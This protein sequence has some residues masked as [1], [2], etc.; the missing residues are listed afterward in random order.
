MNGGCESAQ[1][2]DQRGCGSVQELVA[3]AVDAA[4]ADGP[5]FSPPAVA[6]DLLQWNPVAGATPGGDPHFGIFGQHSL[7]IALCARL[8]DEFA[9]CGAHQFRH[10]WLRRDQWL[11]PFFAE[12]TG[13]GCAIG[14]RTDCLDLRLHIGDHLRATFGRTDDPG[15]RRNVGVN[16]SQRF[17]G[18]A[19]KA[20]AGLENLDNRLLLVR[21]CGDH[22][23]GMYGDD[24]I[25]LRSPGIGENGPPPIR[26]L[27][28]D[29]STIPGAG[30]NAVQFAENSKNDGRAGLQANDTLR[31]VVGGHRLA[32][33][34][35]HAGGALLPHQ[36]RTLQSGCMYSP[37]VLDHFEHPRNAGEVANPDASA[38]IENPACG[39][40]LKLTMKVVGGRI[41][42][43]RF[44]AKGCV[45]AMACGSLLTQLV[46]GRPV[47]EARRLRREEL[48]HS[49]GGL[50]E[51]SGH[52]SHLA[53]DALAAALKQL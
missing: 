18:E 7:R 34:L 49:I 42:E 32:S 51:A 44:Q 39:D 24:L 48:M 27:R 25:G 35:P 2:S 22:E 33:M 14:L 36:Q 12:D 6:S 30:D 10:P 40:I 38:Q 52:A 26:Y 5:H 15:N 43:I 4:F 13:S 28:A 20:R 23:I 47:D 50:P 53:M 37:Q 21:H 8:S 29:I 17:R 11:T 46:Q 16:V 41:A 19:E 45:A 3:N 9:S 31:G 1:A